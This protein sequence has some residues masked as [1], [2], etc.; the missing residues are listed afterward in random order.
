VLKLTDG[1]GLPVP[2]SDELNRPFWDAAREGRFVMPRCAECGRI[3]AP[4]VANC[5]A[6]LARRFEWV[7]TSGRGTVHSF[8]EYH[9][10]WIREYDGRLPYMVAIVEL[11]EGPRLI[12][13]L[14]G[15]ASDW[16]KIGA[17]VR[18]AFQERAEGAQVP[19][20]EHDPSGGPE[21]P[22]AAAG[23]ARGGD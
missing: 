19:V 11:D 5:S 3:M 18:V 12:T 8:I 2:V 1:P 20:F 14:V 13:A 6:C 21:P 23:A 4:P 7:A 9:R 10:S 17:R 15:E 22:A 16:V